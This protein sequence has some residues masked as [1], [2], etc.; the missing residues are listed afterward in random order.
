MSLKKW[1]S[2]LA[3]GTAGGSIFIIV[4]IKYVFYDQQLQAMGINNT[5]SGLLLTVYAIVAILLLLPGGGIAD[6]HS[7]KKIICLSLLGTTVLT[8]VYAFTMNFYISMAI[9]VGFAI[10]A[11]AAFMPCLL[12]TVAALGKPEEQGKMYGI[13]YALNG[14]S[15]TII[16]IAALY[17]CSQ[18]EDVN[19]G[20]FWACMFAAFGTALACAMMYFFFDDEVLEV[21]V[22][23]EDKFQWKDFGKVVRL[24]DTWLLAIGTTVI[25]SVY[26]SNTYFNPYLIDVIGVSP[27]DSGAFTIIRT[28]VFMLIGAP[29]G[30]YLCDKFFKSTA[31]WWVVGLS[32]MVGMFIITMLLPSTMNPTLAAVWTLLPAF[33]TMAIYGVQF[34]ILRELN[35]S[36]AIIG[37]SIGI[38][39]FLSWTPDMYMHTLFGHW[40]DT[41]G[42]D[43]YNYIFIY[44][45]VLSVIG[46]ITGAIVLKRSNARKR[47]AAAAA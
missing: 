7:P 23:D 45:I 46:V 22:A 3:L 12:K 43:G 1:L 17:V 10:T 18:F 9:W 26:S 21:R 35:L 27:T 2:L 34:S 36:P 13:Y 40:L 32:L 29:I 44:L 20:F 37:T 6:R 41:Y 19:Q 11:A 38:G 24:P 28:Y 14:L 47:L 30:G 39:S 33:V 15:A 31:K 25:Y 4:Y 16:N 8:V 5:Q 42:N